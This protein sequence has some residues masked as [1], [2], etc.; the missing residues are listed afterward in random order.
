MDDSNKNVDESWKEKAS[1][2]KEE[3]KNKENFKL[4]EPDFKFFV[5]TLGIQASI[6]LGLIGIPSTSKKEVDLNQA[7][8]IIDTLSM[9]KDKTKGNLN[10]EETNL[11]ENVVYELKINYASQAQGENK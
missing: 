7:K 11:I 8:F 6:A 10:E 2:E 3:L 4:P 1:Q 9:L 5:T